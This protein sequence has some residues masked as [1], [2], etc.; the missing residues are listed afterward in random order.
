[1]KKMR[2]MYAVSFVKLVDSAWMPKLEMEIIEGLRSHGH[3]T[4]YIRIN[5]SANQMS[6]LEPV[7]IQK[8]NNKEDFI[9]HMVKESIKVWDEYEAVKKFNR[10]LQSIIDDTD[11][12]RP[13]DQSDGGN[14]IND[15]DDED[16]KWM[17]ENFGKYEPLGENATEEEITERV[18]EIKNRNAGS[19]EN[20]M[21]M[22]EIYGVDLIREP[23]I[24]TDE[25]AERVRS[26]RPDPKN[27]SGLFRRSASWKGNRE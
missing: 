25:D 9:S 3:P 5:T 23:N 1:M 10:E 15:D 19:W 13:P 2:D 14:Y 20:Y 8:F 21:I 7:K 27:N 11:S 4:D 17:Y 22:R 18:K 6:P 16:E 26:S 24:A 12:F